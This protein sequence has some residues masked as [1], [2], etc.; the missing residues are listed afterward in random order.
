MPSSRVSTMPRKSRLAESGGQ[1]ASE[2]QPL[3]GDGQDQK[4]DPARH[5]PGPIA[6]EEPDAVLQQPAESP[7]A[8]TTVKA[9]ALGASAPGAG[10]D[11]TTE[12]PVSRNAAIG[13]GAPV[14]NA[15]GPGEAGAK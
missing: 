7:K 13:A 6:H 9:F 12:A 1:E 4:G 11:Q 2:F 3:A 14:N 10:H 15:A 8:M 5:Q